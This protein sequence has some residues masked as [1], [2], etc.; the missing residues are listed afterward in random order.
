MSCTCTITLCT[1]MRY[2]GYMSMYNCQK[3]WKYVLENFIFWMNEWTLNSHFAF[4]ACINMLFLHSNT[5]ASWESCLTENIM[6]NIEPFFYKWGK[7]YHANTYIILLRLDFRRYFLLCISVLIS[8]QALS[9]VQMYSGNLTPWCIPM[10]ILAWADWVSNKTWWTFDFPVWGRVK[11]IV[12]VYNTHT[13]YQIKN[14]GKILC[15]I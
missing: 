11:H 7:P 2:V 15:I 14:L 13:S 6:C 10:H 8:S 5:I 1:G 12:P 4:V 3:Y 9:K